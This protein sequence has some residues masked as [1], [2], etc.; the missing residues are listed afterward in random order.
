MAGASCSDVVQLSR[1]ERP[2]RPRRRRDVGGEETDPEERQ[3]QE[4]LGRVRSVLNKL[5]PEM[6][7][8]VM[9][10]MAKIPIQSER[11]LT[12]VV[13]MV[14]KRAISEPKFS[15]PIA[16]MCRCLMGEQQQCFK[17]TDIQE[18]MV[19]IVKFIGELFK[20]KMLAEAIM[21]ECI[22]KMLNLHGEE[23]LVCLCVVLSV[24]G[25][26]LDI[27]KAKPCMDQ[28]FNKI[29]N[30]I[31][32]RQTSNRTCFMLQDVIDLRQAHWVS[33]HGDPGP[34]TI[35][36]IRKQAMEEKMGTNRRPKRSVP[37][38]FLN[39]QTLPVAAHQETKTHTGFRLS[40]I[41]RFIP[42]VPAIKSSLPPRVAPLPAPTE[43]PPPPTAV[44]T[45]AAAAP[46]TPT[47]VA[48]PPPAAAPPTPSAV[49]PSPEAVTPIAAP[50]PTAAGA[51]P[52]APTAVAPPPAPTAVAPPPAPTAVAAAIAAAVAA[53]PP[54]PTAVAPP[55][56]PTAVA[57]PPAPTAVAAA[58][59]AAVAAAPPAPTAV[60]PPPAPT[61]VAPPPAPTAV[62]AAIAAA[63][64]AAPPAPTAV[65]PP[66]APT[67]VAP[68]P[69]P[70]AVAAA[71]AAAVAA[72]PP[73]P[74]A[75]T[76]PP[77]PTAVAPSAAAASP[78]APTAAAAAEAGA[79]GVWWVSPLEDDLSCPVCCDIYTDPVVLPCSHSFCR[80]CLERSWRE[81]SVR[82][83]CLIC[84]QK[85]S[86]HNP[87]PNRAL[88]NVCEAYLKE[89]SAGT[90]PTESETHL[91]Q[92]LCPVHEEKLQ[93]YCQDEEQLVCVECV[94]QEHKTH[95]VC[96]TKKA[97]H[98]RKDE[99]KS[100][101]KSLEDDVKKNKTLLE[102]VMAHI[103]AQAV[104][105]EAQIKE[106]FEKLHQ[107][108]RREEEA[109]IAALRQEERDKTAHLEE[110]MEAIERVILSFSERM[111]PIEKLMETDEVSFLQTF[112]ETKERT[113]EAFLHPQPGFWQLLD[114]SKYLDKL[115]YRV[116]DRME[117]MVAH[118]AVMVGSSDTLQFHPVIPVPEH[119]ERFAAGLDA[120]GLWDVGAVWGQA[121]VDHSG[122]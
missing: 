110:K 84:R 94:T 63:V 55:P 14:I 97:A 22:D 100:L 101:I 62:A 91:A 30:I 43:A 42:P 44:A 10:E 20:L 23:R 52:P 61:A 87:T 32:E 18:R 33:R 39:F 16:N 50:P 8:R 74:T 95:S 105:T 3:T 54:A 56:A 11:H 7:Q 99:L 49:A 86:A 25:K 69:A 112:S 116:W 81:D 37:E 15:V 119:L 28:Y 65:A 82:Q 88:R 47:A 78:G 72:A 76:P 9:K 98:E 83:E 31:K 29:N 71:I 13:E 115:S 27:G 2:W 4:I 46:P 34:Q 80:P 73:A 17:D 41:S 48:P 113:H 53:A 6:F 108:L 77:A 121:S 70:T 90:A 75:V 102:G 114:V 122:F 24:I 103:K 19:G 64:A 118:S 109:R 104:Q 59:A 96:S 35:T 107:F 68:P 5:T 40:Q 66:P 1:A 12:A 51:A 79:A 38:A 89:R 111:K 45:P 58:I 60:A 36:N 85:T 67:A 93:F 21:H 26:D 92:V 117:E 120:S 106:E 57:P